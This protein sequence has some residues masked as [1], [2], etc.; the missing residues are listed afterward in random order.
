MGHIGKAVEPLF[1]PQG[2]NWKLD[3]SL[4]AGVGAKEIVAST[5]GVLYTGD[6]SFSEAESLADVS[7]DS[8]K[9][10]RL[11][12]RME[13]DGMTPLSAYC[14]LL[15]ILIYFPC[16]ATIVAIKSETGTWRWAMAAALYTTAL[17]WTVSCLVYQVGSIIA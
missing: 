14:F 16:I 7:A 15:F 11:H 9:Y 6:D 4:I 5:M 3:V 13:A 8:E 1:L 17:A 10:R 12:N 2:F